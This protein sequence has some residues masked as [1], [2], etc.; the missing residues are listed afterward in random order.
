MSVYLLKISVKQNKILCSSS[1]YFHSHKWPLD[2]VTQTSKSMLMFPA[3]FSQLRS[4]SI[5]GI[6]W[7]NIVGS[8]NASITGH[9]EEHLIS[10]CQ[11]KGGQK[12]PTLIWISDMNVNTS[13]TLCIFG[14]RGWLLVFLCAIEIS[15][16]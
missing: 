4:R 14:G 1:G 9:Q 5:N 3:N 7:L 15:I 12:H 16:Q 13:L 10:N 11:T 6:S 2:S 8:C